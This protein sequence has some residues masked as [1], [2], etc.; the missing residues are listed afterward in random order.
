[1]GQENYKVYGEDAFTQEELHGAIDAA[2]DDFGH[3]NTEGGVDLSPKQRERLKWM[4]FH[5]LDGA[6]QETERREKGE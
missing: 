1:M 2:L 4:I 6:R 5:Q 3:P